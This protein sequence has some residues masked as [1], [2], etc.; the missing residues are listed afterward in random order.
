M[1]AAPSEH[2]A[3]LV[4][5]AYAPEGQ[6][7]QAVEPTAEERPIGQLAQTEAPGRSEYVPAPH[8]THEAEPSVE[9]KPDGQPKQAIPPLLAWNLPE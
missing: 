2:T 9:K 7:V 8:P 4:A 3:A 6:P 1:P 5:A